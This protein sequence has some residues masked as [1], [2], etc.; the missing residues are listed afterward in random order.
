MTNPKDFT[1]GFD[2]KY[3]RFADGKIL[4][5][6]QSY[7]HSDLLNFNQ[8]KPVSAGRIKYYD[9]K[10]QFKDYGSFTLNLK[11]D[12]KDESLVSE[13]LSA[14]GYSLADEYLY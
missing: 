12:A 13:Y 11:W 10:F 14:F 9:R 1:N 3:V 7:N 2:Y 5:Q 8:S 6:D 4:F